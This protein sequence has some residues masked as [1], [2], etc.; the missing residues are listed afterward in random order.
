ME[1]ER[2]EY[3]QNFLR[4][5]IIDQ[6]YSPE[7]FTDYLSSEKGENGLNLENWSFSQLQEIVRNFKLQ[8]S[9]SSFNNQNYEQKKYYNQ[10]NIP[11]INSGK[12]IKQKKN[13][14]KI[15]NKAENILIN[16][17]DVKLKK[18]ENI[19]ET[20][21]KVDI[22]KDKKIN[23]T[24]NINQNQ[25]EIKE[26]NKLNNKEKLKENN[27][28]EI[29]NEN[30]KEEKKEENKIE[31][32]KEEIKEENKK[33][34]IEEE[35]KEENKIENKKE[36]KKEENKIE[37]TEEKKEEKSEEKKEE[38]NKEDNKETITTE[39]KILDNCIEIEKEDMPIEQ[40]KNYIS[41]KKQE[42]NAFSEMTDLKIIITTPEYIKG[43][44]FSFSYYQYTLLIPKLNSECI[45]K[46]SDFEWLQKKLLILFPATF[47]PPLPESSFFDKNTL[48][49]VYRKVRE[50]NYY[51]NTISQN[52]LVRSSNFF[53]DFITL[54]LNEFQRKKKFYD[55]INSPISMQNFTTMEG[56]IDVT[57][58]DQKDSVCCNIISDIKNKSILYNNLD[59]ALRNLILEFDIM[60]TRIN[61]V[62][63]SFEKLSNSYHFTVKGDKINKIL[64]RFS[65][66][67]S[68]W[69]KNYLTQQIFFDE[70]I[71][72]V[73]KFMSKDLINLNSLNEEFS[74][75]RINYMESK[76]LYFS[77]DQKVVKKSEKDFENN[78]I[79]FGFILNRFYD[80]YSRVN[81]EHS[82]KLKNLQIYLQ[83]RK[84]SVFSDYLGLSKLMNME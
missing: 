75:A 10:E 9:N 57:I 1:K 41:C 76:K 42:R 13:N 30:K 51:I 54:P 64:M 63:I 5:E 59:N 23:Q 53:Q 18:A 11:E 48:D 77:K 14:K 46:S 82:N 28:I 40:S 81:V 8:Y 20:F 71:R 68:N 22:N 3:K 12:N 61:D 55:S 39:S 56:I 70:E 34:N 31:N 29:T 17:S 80:E 32:K 15:I 79:C 45:R 27:N 38:K 26:E 72:E 84:D 43:S 7:E 65:E 78:Q 33:E 60:S 24:K 47:F 19:L 50:L 73:F 62:A 69:G 49:N 37:N 44:L 52:I 6:G 16:N 66:S 67:F 35:K 4:T 83:E 58:D 74:C 36:E 21:Q 2:I 25:K